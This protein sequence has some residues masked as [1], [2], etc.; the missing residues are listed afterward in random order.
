M[1]ALD[2]LLCD[3]VDDYVALDG[4]DLN[5]NIDAYSMLVVMKRGS[6]STFDGVCYGGASGAGAKVGFGIEPSSDN[7]LCDTADVGQ[8]ATAG[9]GSKSNTITSLVANGWCVLGYTKP[10]GATAIP[11]MHKYN[12]G[13]TTWSH[14]AGSELMNNVA[15]NLDTFYAG[16]WMDSIGNP[17]DFFIGNLGLAAFWLSNLGSD[18]AVE[19]TVSNLLSMNS[20]IAAGPDELIRFN[21]MSAISATV[22]NMQEF[23]RNGTTLDVGDMPA[24]WTEGADVPGP[25]TNI[26][27]S[28]FPRFLR[29]GRKIK[30]A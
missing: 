12:Y 11:R 29:S 3:G 26:D 25:A 6:D 23:T 16:A 19:S 4:G 10:A 21:T 20:W 27:F 18:G 8:C 2:S 7:I 28:N 17:S 9:A 30:Y 14:E 24:G 13:T 15:A 22:G 1:G 5:T